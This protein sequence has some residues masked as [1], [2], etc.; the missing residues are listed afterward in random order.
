MGDGKKT[1]GSSAGTVRANLRNDGLID[2]AQNEDDA[3]EKERRFD[4]QIWA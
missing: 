2:G 1:L 3:G 4:S